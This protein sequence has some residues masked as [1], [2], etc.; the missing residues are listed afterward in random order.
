MTPGD[1]VEATALDDDI[2]VLRVAYAWVPLS[3][4][5]L[6]HIRGL[7]QRRLLVN[8]CSGCGHWHVPPRSVCPACWS[9][10]VVP[11]EVS[12]RGRIALMTVLHIPPPSAPEIVTADAGHAL[13]GV[14]LSEQPGL[15]VASTVTCCDPR[16]LAIGQAVEL[17]WV[18]RDGSPFPA[19]RPLKAA[20]SR[21]SLAEPS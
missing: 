20:L 6:P 5:T 2:E 4:E 12:G 15:R 7:S 14:E 8:R 18:E 16:A 10:A 21:P 1:A 3:P 13:V 11:T 9:R 19:F 17:E